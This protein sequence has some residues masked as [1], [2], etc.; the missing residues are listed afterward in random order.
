[1]CGAPALLRQV[2]PVSLASAIR[3]H[4]RNRWSFRVVGEIFDAVLLGKS[5]S[6]IGPKDL[7]K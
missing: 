1:M 7:E 5:F 3:Q 6:T 2:A 4:A